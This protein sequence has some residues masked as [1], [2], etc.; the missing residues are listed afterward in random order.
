MKKTVNFD[1]PQTCHFYY[2]NE[3]GTP[4]TILTFFPWPRVRIGYNSSGM[5][6]EIG[7]AVPKDSLDFWT[8]RFKQ[9]NVKHDE[10]AERLGEK[11][12]HF[13]DPD[14]LK[15]DLVVPEKSDERKSWETN[16]ISGVV[17]NKGFHSVTLI[18]PNVDPTASILTELFGYQLLKQEGSRYRFITDAIGNA[19]IV[20]IIEAP[21]LAVGLNAG[22][23]NH[24]VAYRVTDENSQMEFREK[25]LSKGLDITPKIDRDYFF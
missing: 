3:T 25:I 5:V 2:G 14:G 19:S 16:E 20:D 17:A 6:T 8:D 11:Y 12:L 1:D 23:T 24:H 13:E 22:G 7:Y 4:G 21:H 18:E 10:V 9:F 15:I